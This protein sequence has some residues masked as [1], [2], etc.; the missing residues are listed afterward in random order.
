[1]QIYP[2]NPSFTAGACFE[3]A[4]QP[5]TR[6]SVA[7]YQQQDDDSLTSLCGVVVEG[8]NGVTATLKDGKYLFESTGNNVRMRFDE[9]WNW[10]TITIRPNVTD[11]ETG[12][13]VA[14]AYEVDAD[15]KP[16]HELGQSCAA[17]RP[18]FAARPDSD[19][20]ALVIARPRNPTAALAYIVPT[21]TYHAYNSTGGGSFYD[22]R[23]HRYR[24]ANKVSL[25]RPGGGLGARL[26]E[27]VDPYD[28]RSTRQQFAHWDAK[29]IR[30]LRKEGIACDFYTDLDLHSAT[31]LD[32]TRY[33]CMLS[34]GHHEY[35]SEEMRAHV[36]YFVTQG[37][38]LAVFSGNTCYRPV[39]F[40]GSEPGQLTE[41]RKL[42]DNWDVLKERID[43]DPRVSGN[44][45][46]LIGLTYKHGGGHWGTWSRWRRRWVKCERR[47]V[48]FTVKRPEHWIFAGTQLQKDDTF[49]AEDRLVGYEA[50]GIPP[51]WNDDA[52]E[53]LAITD[54]LAGWEMGGAGAIGIFRPLLRDGRRSVG[55][56]FN[57]GTT[58]WARALMDSAAKSNG[59]VQQITRNVIR[60]YAGLEAANELPR[61]ASETASATKE[62]ALHTDAG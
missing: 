9:D 53:T 42:A 16:V 40:V 44:E 58:D 5:N 60:K 55:E 47:A 32:L 19:S 39:R 13:Y 62:A 15:G 4:V 37:G 34:V 17:H 49:G 14:I 48:G 29:F 50:D 3:L 45:S 18:I 33:R 52:F 11:L 20:M 7:L 27:P 41:M 8:K 22:D 21:A 35:W 28:T 31:A 10:P 12:A 23:V 61:H 24:A 57:V 2:I 54:P 46:N 36:A 26:G 25:R 30:W 59:V 1:M 56:V 6:F 38:N 43:L 51:E